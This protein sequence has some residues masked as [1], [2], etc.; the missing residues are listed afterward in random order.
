MNTHTRIKI[1]GLTRQQDI[2]DATALGA[3]A[4]GFVFYPPSPRAVT[5]EQA[6][7]LIKKVP[8]FITTVALFVDADKEH[9][10]Q[11]IDQ[12]QIDLLQF[13]GDEGEAYCQQ[14][15]R[16][17]M[18][19]IRVKTTQDIIQAE[20][21]FPSA[22]ALLLDAYVEHLP[23]GTGQ[24]FDWQLIPQ[25][26]SM[27]WVLAGGLNG[28]NVGQCIEQLMPFAVDVSGGVEAEKGIKDKQKIQ[29]FINEVRRVR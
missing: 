9:V 22:K 7:T 6:H 2:E 5:L 29:H 1:C 12:C 19:A 28:Q 26:I 20:Q 17:Y 24:Q 10:Q 18:K 25:D 16:P 3:D 13:H 8:A 23:G 15:S 21:N 11:V 4:L 14:F 27:P